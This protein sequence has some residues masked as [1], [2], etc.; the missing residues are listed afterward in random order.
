MVTPREAK[1]IDV[2]R[3]TRLVSSRAEAMR[4][5]IKAGI[6]LPRLCVHL[7]DALE[8]SNLSAHEGIK[9]EVEALE[10]VLGKAVTAEDGEQS[11]PHADILAANLSLLTAREREIVKML[12]MG[13]RNG[14]I[15]KELN[16]SLH[17]IKWYLQGIRE[18][19]NVSNRSEFLSTTHR[20]TVNG[21]REGSK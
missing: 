19:L 14:A 5:L 1:A 16:L 13:L 4:M 2:W 11:L 8:A 15:A 18:K 3:S 20:T 21:M 12:Q 17:T 10:K 7:L 9:S 6:D